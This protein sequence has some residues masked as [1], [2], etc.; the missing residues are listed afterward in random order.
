M[1]STRE[2]GDALKTSFLTGDFTPD[3]EDEDEDE[4]ND[5]KGE[6]EEEDHRLTLINF[7]KTRS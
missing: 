6:E 4:N 5:D 7:C 1:E 2:R 3:D